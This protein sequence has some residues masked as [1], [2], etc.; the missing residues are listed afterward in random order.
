MSVKDY[1]VEPELNVSIS[2]INIAE[3][4]A[5]SGINDAIR[6]LMADLKEEQN[7]RAARDSGQDAATAAAQ[8]S[9][10]DA[11]TAADAAKSTADGKAPKA[12]ASTATTY[13]IGTGSNYGHVK[14]SDSTSSTSAASKGIAASPKAV[15]D[16]YDKA[17]AAYLPVGSVI[18]FAGNPSSAP[19]GYLLCNGAAVSRT[20]YASLFAAIGTTYGTGNGSSTFNLPNLTDKFIQ[21]SGTAGTAK[22]AGLPGISGSLGRVP[23]VNSIEAS[24]AFILDGQAGAVSTGYNTTQTAYVGLNASRSSEIYGSSTTVQPPAVTMRYYIK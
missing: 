9:A 20:T 8:K 6:Q 21:G 13:G 22:A 19:S 7:A 18:A 5:P 4:C 23:F 24:G 3:G 14:L 1:N 2:G 12:H 15:K 17:V 10:D 16:A 11:Q